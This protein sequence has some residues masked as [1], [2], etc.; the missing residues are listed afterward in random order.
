MTGYWD[1][2]GRM[3]S[4]CHRLPP[5]AKLSVALI[6]VVVSVSIP[7]QY[8]PAHGVLGCLIFAGHS[9]A[10][11]PLKYVAWRLSV[12]LPMLFLLSISI[13]MSQGFEHG[14]DIMMAVFLRGTLAFCAALW[15]INV[16]PFD[17]LLVTLRSMKVSDV[18]VAILSFMYRYFFVLGDE[19]EKLKT[20]RRARTLGHPHVVLRWQS[21]AFLI[22]MLLIRAMA[23]AER[24]HGAMLARGWDGRVRTLD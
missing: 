15:L 10:R 3:P 24:V 12:F 14:W 1:R 20:A 8:W 21:S 9:L 18:L 17:Q 4:M 23:R 5:R 19:L 13:P 7:I 6:V 16:M 11:I 22:G 2:Y